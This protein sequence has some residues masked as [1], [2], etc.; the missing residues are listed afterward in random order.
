MRRATI[1]GMRRAAAVAAATA[2]VALTPAAP[3]AANSPVYAGCHS[4]AATNLYLRHGI[5]TVFARRMTCRRA[6]RTLGRWARNGMRGRGP[7]GWRCRERA[8]SEHVQR[9]RCTRRGKRMRFDVGG[10]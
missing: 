2:V 1:E 6:V 5:S 4:Q 3:A 7:H 8:L 9:V 10:G